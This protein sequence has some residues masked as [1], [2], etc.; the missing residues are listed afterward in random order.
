[1]DKE[2]DCGKEDVEIQIKFSTTEGKHER[3]R[4]IKTKRLGNMAAKYYKI[5]E[6]R[7]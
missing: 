7:K 2:D 1:M 4:D 5:Q 6:W 3:K